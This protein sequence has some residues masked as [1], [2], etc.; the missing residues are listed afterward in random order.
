MTPAEDFRR[1]PYY[2]KYPEKKKW[3]EKAD[4]KAMVHLFEKPEDVQIV[5]VGGQAGK[6]SAYAG[7]HPVNPH[8]IECSGEGRES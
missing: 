5:V 6:S 3:L 1:S 2:K 4:A 7:F 8:L